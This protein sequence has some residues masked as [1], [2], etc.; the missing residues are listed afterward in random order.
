MRGGVPD[1][2]QMSQ[3]EEQNR[4]FIL[5]LALVFYPG[6][7]PSAFCPPISTRIFSTQ[8]DSNANFFWKSP[9]RQI[10]K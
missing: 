4:I 3:A 7:Q 1:G 2:G 5:P 9:Q 10:P 8:V 6:L